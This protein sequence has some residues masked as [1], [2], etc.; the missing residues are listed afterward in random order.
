MLSRLIPKPTHFRRFVL[1]SS[2]YLSCAQP[3]F[4]YSVKTPFFRT[5]SEYFSTNSN[6]NNNGQDPSITSVWKDFRESE[7]KF[8]VTF[9]KE[10]GRFAGFNDVDEGSQAPASKDQW[11]LEEKSLDNEDTDA[12]F[13]GVDQNTE[14]KGGGFGNQQWMRAEDPK[15]WTLREEGKEDVF[16]FQDVGSDVGEFRPDSSPVESEGSKDTE[17]LEKD[18]QALIAVLKGN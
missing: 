6:N 13:K 3:H 5:S 4:T 15:P 7:G 2:K 11:W 8:D 9:A 17:N 12:I 18:E 1:I 16:N 10:S 14:E